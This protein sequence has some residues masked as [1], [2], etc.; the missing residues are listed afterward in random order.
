MFN[1]IYYINGSNLNDDE[2]NCAYFF[3]KHINCFDHK[4]YLLINYNKKIKNDDNKIKKSIIFYVIKEGIKNKDIIFKNIILNVK[5]LFLLYPKNNKEIRELY[6]KGNN[7]SSNNNLDNENNFITWYKDIHNI[8]TN[9]KTYKPEIELSKEKHN[10]SNI[11]DPIKNIVL[12]S[13]NKYQS[14]LNNTGLLGENYIKQD[15]D[16]DIETKSFNTTKKDYVTTEEHRIMV[17]Q[18]S[19]L[20]S[21]LGNVRTQLNNIKKHKPVLELSKE[22]QNKTKFKNIYKNYTTKIDF[23]DN[24]ELNQILNTKNSLYK[25][26]D[27]NDN[28]ELNQILNTKNSFYKNIYY[29]DQKKVNK[30]KKIKYN[31]SINDKKNKKI[32][33]RIQKNIMKYPNLFHKTILNIDN[34]LKYEIIT[35]NNSDNYIKNKFFVH[36]HCF[37]LN[38]FNEIYGPYMNNINEYFSV[39]ITY[40]KEDNVDYEQFNKY[41]LIKIPNVGMD[42]GAKLITIYYLNE[43]KINYSHILF[44]HSKS[45]IK[46]RKIYYSF[47]IENKRQINYICNIASKYDAI[48]PN[49]KIRGDWNKGF[50]FLNKKCYDEFN[51]LYN[52]V[53]LSDIF[54]EGNVYMF[55]KKYI[56]TI[57]FHN[58]IIKLFY[59][60]LNA[61]NSFDSNWFSLY[62]K[63]K[64]PNIEQLYHFYKNNDCYGNCLQTTHL[65]I[66]K[67]H[68]DI[69]SDTNIENLYLPDANIEHVYE[70]LWLNFCENHDLNYIIID[71][72]K[73]YTH[74]MI[75]FDINIYKLLNKKD[76][77][78]STIEN[79]Y[80]L[81]NTI[82]SNNNENNFIFNL[83]TILENL[84]I[85]FNII[86][87]AVNNQ[88]LKNNKYEIINHYIQNNY[89][90]SSNTFFS[91]INEDYKSNIKSFAI[92]FP[93]FHEIS[94]NNIVWGDGFTEWDNLK[95]TFL[96]NNY[97]NN[98]HPHPDITFYNLL[99]DKHLKRIY[100]YCNDYFIDGF[101]VYHYWFDNVPIMSGVINKLVQK[102]II[103][104]KVWFFSWVNEHWFKK[105]DDSDDNKSKFKENDVIFQQYYNLDE[106]NLHYRYLNNFFH[107]PNY[108]KPNNKPWLCIYRS[109]NIPEEYL[110]HLN[111]L[112]IENG[113]DGL[114]FINTLNNNPGGIDNFINN[115]VNPN[116]FDYDFEF[117]PNCTTKIFT[118]KQF[119][120]ED[121]N[122]KLNL[123]KYEK[124]INK[125]QDLYCDKYN[126]QDIYTI[127][128]KYQKSNHKLIRGIFTGWDNL[129]RYSSLSKKTTIFFNSNSFDFYLL[130]LKQFL[131]LEK[132]N[133]HK[134]EKYHIINSLNEWC[135]Q[136]ILEPS[137][138]MNYSFLLAYKYAKTTNLENIN[139]KIIDDMINF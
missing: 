121:R 112:A 93:Q 139:E 5:L 69:L 33:N 17:S 1:Y 26:I 39:I 92:V 86:S 76:D 110:E 68:N 31:L 30:P 77:F 134:D 78:V 13:F 57:F 129:P 128:S 117:S 29:N 58:N 101:M 89:N 21:E 74:E 63:I 28:E 12:D 46:R 3:I 118:T 88:L 15:V 43:K 62:Y 85:D 35:S 70:R 8:L 82:I 136:A 108:Y 106:I 9:I 111:K 7:T 138:E 83:K 25:N 4:Y 16:K 37:N 48:F 52:L 98:L 81:Q 91:N 122:Q 45:D 67:N 47:F 36:L 18:V 137:I 51:K 132:E 66:I 120:F 90:S 87:Y 102:G 44:L 11:L 79:I 54:I 75:D 135:E 14:K 105:W 38:N 40:S 23:N 41:T 97:H 95:K 53:H 72:Y 71:K 80:N 42:V 24:E 127:C 19:Q 27:F 61:V 22:K 20:L 104:N 65:P 126:I 116:L 34:T 123:E 73:D 59:N 133:T 113:F 94:I 125:A 119:E 131:L 107:T 114:T 84:P 96:I 64:N 60:N 100:D 32:I 55:S 124:F 6:Q 109:N 99:E 49:L 10:N 130:C 103:K 50:Y 115:D 56:E 2:K